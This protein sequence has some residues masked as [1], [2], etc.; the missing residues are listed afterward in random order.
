MV[1][2][3]VEVPVVAVLVPVVLVVEPTVV[4]VVFVV[5][6]VLVF[7][8]VPVVA[9]LIP[10]ISH[11]WCSCLSW[12][13]GQPPSPSC[14]CQLVWC[15]WYPSFPL[16]HPRSDSGRFRMGWRSG[17][18]HGGSAS[19]CGCRTCGSAR[20]SR[21]AGVRTVVLAMEPVVPVVH[22]TVAPVSPVVVLA[23]V[24]RPGRQPGR[25]RR[26]CPRDSGGLLARV[27][28]PLSSL[29]FVAEGDL[30]LSSATSLLCR[31]GHGYHAQHD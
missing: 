21:G 8:E 24:W 5:P 25:T 28:P 7:V 19:G 13:P 22:V 4:V 26:G 23:V 31:K 27:R 15:L 12:C 14:P 18:A 10:G 3:P 2:V 6:V 20:R 1:L 29:A 11:V 9:V 30:L 17:R 16:S